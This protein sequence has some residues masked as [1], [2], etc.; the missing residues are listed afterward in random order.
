MGRPSKPRDKRNTALKTNNFLYLLTALVVFLVGLPILENMRAIPESLEAPIAFTLLLAI[1]LWSIRRPSRQFHVALTLVVLSMLLN[2]IAAYDDDGLFDYLSL[3]TI[4]AFLALSAAGALRLVFSAGTVDVNRIM[5]AVCV[6]LLLGIM[7]AIAY[8][9]VYS[10]DPGAFSGA[11]KAN[12][13]TWNAQWI[14]YSFVTLTT[15]GYGDILPVS[16]TARALAYS[17]AIFGVFYMAVLVALLVG[18]Y[19]AEAAGKD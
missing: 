7:W 1:G 2:W 19:Q 9:V 15:L 6:Y 4:F 5:G 3:L 13:G 8:A 12:V 16:A 17:Q 14:Y 18:A 10:L 11:I